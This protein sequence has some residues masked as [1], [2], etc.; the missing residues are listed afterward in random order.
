MA[1]RRKKRSKLQNRQSAKSAPVHWL[2]TPDAVVETDH[3]AVREASE[4]DRQWFEANPGA[5][6]RIRHVIE[7]EFGGGE[8]SQ[9]TTHV[10]VTQIEPGARFRE[11][12]RMG[13]F[14]PGSSR[15]Q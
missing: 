12:L 8:R 3:E 10:R 13:F 11:R 7:G 5:T 1:K 14:A 2:L 9:G 4:M 15:V 6:E